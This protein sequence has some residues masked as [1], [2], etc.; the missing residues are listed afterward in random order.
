MG[1]P[2]TPIRCLSRH[3][4]VSQ[5]AEGGNRI[6]G[7]LLRQL[8]NVTEQS[9]AWLELQTVK[10]CGSPETE[11]VMVSKFK[12]GDD[13]YLIPLELPG[14]NGKRTPEE[15]EAAEALIA[16]VK[17]EYPSAYVSTV[18]WGWRIFKA[19]V[20][21]GDRELYKTLIHEEDVMQKRKI[22]EDR[23]IISDEAGKAMPC[24]PRLSNPDYDPS[25]P[26]DKD[27]PK[28]L[29]NSCEGCP[30]NT[31]DRPDF[32]NQSLEA[33]AEQA[34]DDDEDLPDRLKTTMQSESDRYLAARNEV[35]A[36]IAKEYPDR[37][38][39]FSMLLSEVKRSEVAKHLGKNTSSL[40]KIS[41]K[42]KRDLWDLLDSLWYLN[43]NH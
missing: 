30:Y 20:I 3:E 35:L 7:Q 26:N 40:Y 24:P 22:L 16:G 8:A 13:K 27:N 15:A 11:A 42:L 37:L 41:K 43:L 18:K 25:K 38:L 29:K 10:P 2:P 23:C 21:E 14:E 31:F 9:V 32:T 19:V 33:M 1:S 12:I 4:A 17:Q 6:N 39:E 34:E 36:F 5:V 28:T